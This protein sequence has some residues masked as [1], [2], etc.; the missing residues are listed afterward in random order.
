L[1]SAHRSIAASVRLRSLQSR[2]QHEP[3]PAVTWPSIAQGPKP[4]DHRAD[5]VFELGEHT[6]AK[7]C[8]LA[9]IVPR[10]SDGIPERLQAFAGFP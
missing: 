5:V 7:V 3:T 10:C 1:H 4:I 9:R 2:Q 6:A 8:I